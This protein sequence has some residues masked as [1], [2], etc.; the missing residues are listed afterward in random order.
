MSVDPRDYPL[1]VPALPRDG[2]VEPRD[3]D[4]LAPSNAGAEGELGNPHGP[5]VVS[6]GIH[7]Y[8]GVRPICTGEVASD[9]TAQDTAED[10]HLATWQEATVPPQ[11]P[12]SDVSSETT[13]EGTSGAA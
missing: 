11:E 2:A 1:T 12:V 9:P 5:S 8:Q 7:A 6:P 10:E 4:F 3:G 13:M